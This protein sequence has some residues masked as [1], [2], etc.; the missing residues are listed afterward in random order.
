MYGEVVQNMRIIE[1]VEVKSATMCSRVV[2][3]LLSPMFLHHLRV[4]YEVDTIHIRKRKK[5]G[6]TPTEVCLYSF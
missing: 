1:E 2:C 6:C 5:E 4:L 3:P